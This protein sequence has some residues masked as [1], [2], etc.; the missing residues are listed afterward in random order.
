[1]PNRR[2]ASQWLAMARPRA[3]AVRLERFRVGPTVGGTWA[4]GW[5]GG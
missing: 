4:T 1:M 2:A 3:E 5:R